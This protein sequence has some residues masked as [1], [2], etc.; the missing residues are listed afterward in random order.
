MFVNPNQMLYNKIMWVYIVIGIGV[1]FLLLICFCLAVANFSFDNFKSKLEEARQ[2]GNSIGINCL[3]YVD[4]INEK[5]L[6]GKLRIER[7]EKYQDH[8]SVGVIALSNE[9]MYSNS[10][11]S[12]STVSHELGHAIQY[13]K[14][15]LTKQWQQRKKNRIYGKFFIPF[16]LIGLV[17]AI[18][19]LVGV[20]P[21]YCLYIGIGFF[22][23]AFIIFLIAIYTKYM[24]IKIEKGASKYA[25][26]ILKEYLSPQE[27]KICNEFLNSARL[28][29][30][31]SLFRTMFGWTFLT[32]K[33]SMFK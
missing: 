20:L 4:E 15:E 10:L 30:W 22:G 16:I 31:G 6:D 14:G 7:C 26:G 13:K 27:I 19:N 5:H 28:T 17:L 23:L 9:T 3:D 1:A 25:I 33:D 32:K 29:Y 24:E 2:Y 8:F 21:S 12:L 11:A 18:L